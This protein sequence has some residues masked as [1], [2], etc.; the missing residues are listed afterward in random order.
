M[1][2]S[3]STWMLTWA[4]DSFQLEDSRGLQILYELVSHPEQEFHVTD[5]LAPRGQAG[6]VEDAGEMLD[7]EAVANYRRRVRE[8]ESE[9]EEAEQWNDAGRVEWLGTELEFVRAE[10]TRAVG[11]GGRRRH[12]A[13]SSER[14]RVNVRRRIVHV[15]DKIEA[16]CPELAQ[17]LGLSVKTGHF[18]AYHPAGRPR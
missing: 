11:L 1:Q 17:H 2:R 15:L 12:A 6:R 4:H 7:S 13:S 10:L 9:L 14:A 8:L 16:H 3:D 18:C 5:L